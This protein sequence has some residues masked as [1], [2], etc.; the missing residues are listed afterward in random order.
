LPGRIGGF[1]LG[2]LAAAGADVALTRWP[3]HGYQP[4]L[5]ILGLALPFMFIHQ[6]TRGVVRTRVVESLADITT[7]LLAVCAIGGL[8]LLRQQGNGD[9]T[10]PAVIAAVCA[11]LVASHLTDAVLP[12]PRFDPTIDR[13]LPAVIVGVAVGAGVGLLWLRRIIDFTGGRGAFAGAAVAAVACLLS[14]GAAFAAGH[15]T[16]GASAAAAVPNVAPEPSWAIRLRPVAA[17]LMTIAFS[18][19]AG[20]VVIT[21]LTS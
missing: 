7:M 11:A 20:Y 4:V 1:I 2:L 3:D 6:L 12:A 8:L 17:V 15:S 16:M 14:I 10:T 21:A 13:G 19:P 9:V 5:G 18:A